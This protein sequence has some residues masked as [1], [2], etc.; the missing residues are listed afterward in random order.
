MGLWDTPEFK[1][2][3]PKTGGKFIKLTDF[4]TDA[5]LV[6]TLVD[7]LEKV[8]DDEL[9]AKLTSGGS[10]EVPEKYWVY[11]FQDVTNGAPVE[12]EYSAFKANTAL[13]IALRTAKIEAGDMFIIQR[14]GEKAS[15]RF[16]ITKL[17]QDVAVN[18]A[19]IAKSKEGVV[20]E[21]NTSDIPF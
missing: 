16:A 11:Y 15:M 2:D 7:R 4:P 13:T 21:V 20:P 1:D 9:R 17:G 6:L 19:M 18:E 10:T 3:K 12:R 5:P 14:S 8:M